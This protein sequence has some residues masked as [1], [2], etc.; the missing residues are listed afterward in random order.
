MDGGGFAGIACTAGR[1]GGAGT[2]GRIGA[3]RLGGRGVP[4]WAIVGTRG[5]TVAA[6]MGDR[7]V[8]GAGVGLCGAARGAVGPAGVALGAAGGD[9]ADLV[10]AGGD[11]APG[12]SDTT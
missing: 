8:I 12:G 2:D 10:E 9:G 4:G 6:E 7:G 5:A 11:A 3:L 1:R